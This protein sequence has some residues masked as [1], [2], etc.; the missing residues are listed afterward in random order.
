MPAAKK[1][2]AKTAD[3]PARKPNPALMK[4]VQPDE[5]LA[6]IVGSKPLPRSQMT[7]N[8]WD[9]IKKNNLQDPMLI[10]LTHQTTT[11]SVNECSICHSLPVCQSFSGSFL[12]MP[13][14]RLTWKR[15]VGPTAS[16]ALLVKPWQTPRAS[17][18][19]HRSSGAVSAASKLD[20][21]R[22]QSCRTAIPRCL[23]GSGEPILC[24]A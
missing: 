20:S 5:V 4:P 24:P 14:A 13:P 17:R 15:S 19:A 12:T 11:G 6:V 16:P 3:K 9:Y 23:R 22:E 8:L 1:P 10:R 21:R 7:K 2:A 18:R